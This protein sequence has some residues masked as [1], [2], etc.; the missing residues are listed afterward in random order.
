MIFPAFLALKGLKYCSKIVNT[1]P[2]SG[3]FGGCYYFIVV[4]FRSVHGMVSAGVSDRG[5]RIPLRRIH[6]QHLR[7][8][9]SHLTHI[10]D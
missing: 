3:R 9:V 6:T 4:F 8:S 5:T 10:V 2:H 7:A 1:N